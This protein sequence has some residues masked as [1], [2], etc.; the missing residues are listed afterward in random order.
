MASIQRAAELQPKERKNADIIRIKAGHMLTFDYLSSHS[1][2]TERHTARNVIR[3]NIQRSTGCL[4]LPLTIAYFGFFITSVRLHEDIA[5]VFFLESTFRDRLD[6]MFTEANT[7]SSVW[8]TLTDTDPEKFVGLFFNHKDMYG[9]MQVRNLT[10]DWWG[11]ALVDF[12]G[13]DLGSLW[14]KG[15]LVDF[16]RGG[17]P[18]SGQVL[19]EGLAGKWVELGKTRCRPLR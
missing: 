19:R 9:K 18:G 7:V 17:S 12:C 4:A 6:A 1:D 13:S 16:D 10:E 11:H 15:D 5:N 2:I 14:S 8:D 3:K